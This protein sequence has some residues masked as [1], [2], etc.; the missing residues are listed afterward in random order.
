VGFGNGLDIEIRFGILHLLSSSILIWAA[1][2]ILS[3]N[4]KYVML[5]VG[6]T[7]TF[8]IICVFAKTLKSTV[9][10]AKLADKII[11]LTETRKGTSWSPG[12]FFPFVP[13]SGVFFTAAALSPFIFPKKESYLK[14]LDG[15]WNKP[16]CFIGRH[17]LVVYCAHTVIFV[18]FFELIGLLFYDGFVF[19]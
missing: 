6:L 13:W 9:Y 10:A 8:T 5:I 16:I 17:A 11:F 2:Q 4:N 14:K 15:K 3:K 12:D 1:L 7:I 19:A 18:V